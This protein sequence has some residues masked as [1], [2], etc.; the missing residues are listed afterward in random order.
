MH[1]ISLPGS[2]FGPPQLICTNC[3]VL[4]KV[5]CNAFYFWL[6]IFHLAKEK[7]GFVM[8]T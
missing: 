1:R 4:V 8:R 3:N 5:P 2:S 7:V 6:Q